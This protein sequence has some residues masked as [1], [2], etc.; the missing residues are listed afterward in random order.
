[1]KK[2]PIVDFHFTVKFPIEFLGYVR[3]SYDRLG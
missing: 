2:N 3:L 1:M